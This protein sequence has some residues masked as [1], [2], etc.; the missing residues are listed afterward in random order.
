MRGA[1]PRMALFFQQSVCCLAGA[2]ESPSWYWLTR[3]MN[4]SSS[5]CPLLIQVCSQSPFPPRMKSKHWARVGWLKRSGSSQQKWV[6]QRIDTEFECDD[7]TSAC[8]NDCRTVLAEN[9][10]DQ[11]RKIMILFQLIESAAATIFFTSFGVE[12]RWLTFLTRS[13]P[14]Y[15]GHPVGD[16]L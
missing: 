12:R 2:D 1:L 13:T 10:I 9:N 6:R 3:F 7:D 15:H 16:D 8:C 14:H 5:E 11:D 4:V